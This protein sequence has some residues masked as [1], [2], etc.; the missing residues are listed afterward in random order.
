MFS[1]MQRVCVWFLFVCSFLV[2]L[3]GVWLLTA[4]RRT[5]YTRFFIACFLSG[6]SLTRFFLF[7]NAILTIYIPGF[8]LQAILFFSLHTDMHS[9][10]RCLLCQWQV[11]I[12]FPGIK[13]TSGTCGRTDTSLSIP[14]LFFQ[15][16]QE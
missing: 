4:S 10:I 15:L 7:E 11:S 3:C 8:D 5:T 1:H 2:L 6:A 14:V 16:A 12:K 9:S 13:P